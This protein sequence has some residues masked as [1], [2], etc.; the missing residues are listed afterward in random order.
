MKGRL[1]GLIL[2][3]GGFHHQQLHNARGMISLWQDAL[4]A[5]DGSDGFRPTPWGTVGFNAA[6]AS[7]TERLAWLEEYDGDKDLS[8]L[9][10]MPRPTLELL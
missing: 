4:Q 2:L 3:A 7:V 9:W 1:Q 5:L 8:P 10:A 6:L